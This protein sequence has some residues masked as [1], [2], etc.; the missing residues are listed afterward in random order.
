[1]ARTMRR[2]VRNEKRKPKFEKRKE[3]S[4]RASGLALRYKRQTQTTELKIGHYMS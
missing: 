1:M 4:L 2:D 3:K